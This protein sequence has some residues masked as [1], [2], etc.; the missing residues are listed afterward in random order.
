MYYYY[1]LNHWNLCPVDY[2]GQRK[3]QTSLVKIW[4]RKP[5]TIQGNFSEAKTKEPFD[6]RKFS[7]TQHLESTL[8]CRKMII[9]CIQGS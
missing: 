8:E 6:I 5:A 1:L 4:T 9:M 3:A 7:I 2:T